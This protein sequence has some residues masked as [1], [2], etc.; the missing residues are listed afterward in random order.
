MPLASALARSCSSRKLKRREA[1][2]A[3]FFSPQAA[4]MPH[5][6]R[7]MFIEKRITYVLPSRNRQRKFI[8]QSLARDE[9]RSLPAQPNGEQARTGSR[10]AATP[11]MRLLI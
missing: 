11:V 10:E 3:G 5:H 8:V 7:R 6:L 9:A 1:P 2:I 4:A